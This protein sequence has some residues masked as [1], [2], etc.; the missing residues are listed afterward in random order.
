MTPEVGW[1]QF[2]RSLAAYRVGS[3]AGHFRGGHDGGTMGL[4][5]AMPGGFGAH[6]A[7]LGQVGG[8]GIGSG[9]PGEGRR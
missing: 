7:A 1:A 5:R 2:G 6:V 3:P 4:G 9:H 8:P